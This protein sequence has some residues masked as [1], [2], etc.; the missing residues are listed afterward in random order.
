M[1]SWGIRVI[2][3]YAEVS[4]D[5]T[6]VTVYIKGADLQNHYCNSVYR[7]CAWDKVKRKE[8]SNQHSAEI[9]M[10]VRSMI[11]MRC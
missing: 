5:V 2:R 8:S 9:E 6:A 3:L 7:N 10:Q 4:H 11:N 1:H